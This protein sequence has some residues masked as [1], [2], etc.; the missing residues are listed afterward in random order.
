MLSQPIATASQRERYEAYRSP[1]IEDCPPAARL[2]RQ[3]GDA[4]D[5]DYAG[6]V[7]GRTCRYRQGPR[8]EE[9]R[10]VEGAR[11]PA[12]QDRRLASRQQGQEVRRQRLYRLPEGD[13]LSATRAGNAQGRDRQ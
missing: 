3:G 9:P 10:T 13:R 11:Y 5:R 2:H 1:R 6:R 8:T 4:E 12:S 7:L